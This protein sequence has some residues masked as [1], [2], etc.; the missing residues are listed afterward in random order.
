MPDARCPLWV[1]SGH[2][3]MSERCPLYPQKRTLLSVIG[4]SLCAKS[5]HRKGLIDCRVADAVS[6]I[7]PAKMRRAAMRF[8]QGD[9]SVLPIRQKRS[10]QSAICWS[11]IE[12]LWHSFLAYC[13]Q[14]KQIHAFPNIPFE[15]MVCG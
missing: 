3:A 10:A 1:I 6:A 9:R 15:R 5:G 8:S 4:M 7:I 14:H 11:G 2:S 12:F 13:K